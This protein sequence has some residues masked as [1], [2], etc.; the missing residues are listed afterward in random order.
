MC[1]RATACLHLFS[2]RWWDSIWDV[3]KKSTNSATLDLRGW[4]CWLS[5]DSFFA[6][7]KFFLGFFGQCQQAKSLKF[8]T[9]INKKSIRPRKCLA[10]VVD[11]FCKHNKVFFFYFPYSFGKCKWNREHVSKSFTINYNSGQR[12]FVARKEKS[13]KN[14]SFHYNSANATP[15]IFGNLRKSRGKS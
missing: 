3:V 7:K 2:V 6:V 10:V 5:R 1:E 14:F 4:R 11:V 12:K 13:R 15:E 8:V 9:V